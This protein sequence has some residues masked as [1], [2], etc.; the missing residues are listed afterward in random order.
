MGLHKVE[1]MVPHASHRGSRASSRIFVVLGLL[2]IV[3]CAW[4]ATENLRLRAD[5]KRGKSARA[6][7]ED[8]LQSGDLLPDIQVRP[9]VGKLADGSDRASLHESI[10]GPA[11]LFVFTSTCPYCARSVPLV[12][13]LTA[14]LANVSVELVGITLDGQLSY[15]QTSPNLP[16]RV[17]G[18]AGPTDAIGLKVGRVPMFL[19]VDED[20]RVQSAWTGQLMRGQMQPMIEAARRLSG[21]D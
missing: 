13:E 11:L 7:P 12:P 20:K 4:L 1:T 17:W 9:V 8:M 3:L 16:Y 18:P 10:D 15:A 2:A 21:L 5:L 6:G 19:L 14:E